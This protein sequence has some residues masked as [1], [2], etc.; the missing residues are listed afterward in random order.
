MHPGELYFWISIENELE[1]NTAKWNSEK[2]I[3]IIKHLLYEGLIIIGFTV[4]NESL[5]FAIFKL[6]KLEF[7][8]LL[9]FPCS[10]S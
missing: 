4:D 7:K 1:R 5:S 2:L 8:H 6:L 10:V 9:P 3:P